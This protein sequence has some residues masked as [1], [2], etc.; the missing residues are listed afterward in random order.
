MLKIYSSNLFLIMI[1]HLKFQ[2]TFKEV[3]QLK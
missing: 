3:M 1:I 2:I